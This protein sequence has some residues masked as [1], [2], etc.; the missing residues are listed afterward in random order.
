MLTLQFFSLEKTDAKNRA[1]ELMKAHSG[2]LYKL[3]RAFPLADLEERD[4][5]QEIYINLCQSLEQFR[6]EAS[7]AT[8][9][10]RIAL[11]TILGFKRKEIH[12]IKLSPVGQ[13]PDPIQPASD[14]TSADLLQQALFQLTELE[15]AM[16]IMYLEGYTQQ[17]IG[18]EFGVDAGHAG[19]KIH[20]IKKKL[21]QWLEKH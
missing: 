9:V 19:V 6:G 13:L 17:E 8:W 15:R 5:F 10:Y 21:Q 12:T 3:V 4:I 11:N 16:V 14:Y 1:L 18:V 7:P 20:R 2:L